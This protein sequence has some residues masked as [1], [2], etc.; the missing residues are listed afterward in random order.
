[1]KDSESSLGVQQFRPKDTLHDRIYSMSRKT[2]S[3]LVFDILNKR[4]CEASQ[5][6]L[7]R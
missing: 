1:M 3:G 6:L 4:D 7:G 5:P 2:A